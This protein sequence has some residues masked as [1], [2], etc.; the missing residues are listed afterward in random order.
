MIVRAGVMML[1]FSEYG[2]VRKYFF[3]VYFSVVAFGL[4]NGLVLMP[5]LL[6]LVGP[7]PG[8][9]PVQVEMVVPPQGGKGEDG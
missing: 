6:H 7:L 3:A 2:F 1:V 5:V 4:L 8:G 9:R